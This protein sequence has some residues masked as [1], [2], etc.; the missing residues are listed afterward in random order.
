MSFTAAIR[1]ESSVRML[2]VRSGT[3]SRGLLGAV[4]SAESLA[5]EVLESG[6]GE[7]GGRVA[8]EE[9]LSRGVLVLEDMALIEVGG[10]RTRFARRKV[11]NAVFEDNVSCAEFRSAQ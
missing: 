2:V 3:P 11:K 8:E 7:G 5:N 1:S 6:E 9:G 10:G 4:S